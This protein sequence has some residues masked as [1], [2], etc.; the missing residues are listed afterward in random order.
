MAPGGSSSLFCLY[1]GS[2][3]DGRC[4]GVGGGR[5]CGGGSGG[6]VFTLSVEDGAEV[7]EG[8]AAELGF[9][10]NRVGIVPWL[11]ADPGGDGGEDV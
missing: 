1:F 6:R 2:E 9:G 4:A 11:F 5:P 8:M 10:S 3:I 7:D